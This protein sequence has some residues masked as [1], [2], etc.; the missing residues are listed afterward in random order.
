MQIRYI[1]IES[2]LPPR[3]SWYCY[4]CIHIVQHKACLRRR[5]HS[6]AFPVIERCVHEAGHGPELPA[7]ECRGPIQERSS[8]GQTDMLQLADDDIPT[9]LFELAPQ[10]ESDDPP[11]RHRAATSAAKPN[12]IIRPA[13][14]HQI[15]RRNSDGVARAQRPYTALV[16]TGTGLWRGAARNRPTTAGGMALFSGRNRPEFPYGPSSGLI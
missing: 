9:I 7:L 13:T 15:E 11:A 3:P 5:M 8:Q 2:C 10:E 12:P 4:G 1:T 6:A 14:A 16:H